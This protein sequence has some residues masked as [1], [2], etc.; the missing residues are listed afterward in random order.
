MDC[1]QLMKFRPVARTLL[2]AQ[3]SLGNLVMHVNHV[4]YE[5]LQT[6][7]SLVYFLKQYPRFI[8]LSGKCEVYSKNSSN[9]N[10]DKQCS[11]SI[12]KNIPVF[13]TNKVKK[14]LSHFTKILIYSIFNKSYQLRSDTAKKKRKKKVSVSD[15]N[16]F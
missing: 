15:V 14:L 10:V 13:S 3:Q 1:I 11:T 6:Y 8:L 4:S 5:N 2:V 16:S 7:Q 12:S 9:V